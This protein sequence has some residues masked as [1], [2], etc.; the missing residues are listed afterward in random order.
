MPKIIFDTKDEIPES[1]RA[2]VVEVDGKFE[3]DAKGV[4]DKNKELL[5]DNSKLKTD[6]ANLETQ[7]TELKTKSPDVPRGH[8]IV[9]LDIAELG[10]AAKGAGLVKDELPTLKTTVSDLQ[11]KIAERDA[12]EINAKVAAV[13]KKDLAAWREHAKANGLRFEQRDEGGKAD[14]AVFKKGADGKEVETKLG[15]YVKTSASHVKDGDGKPRITP[16]PEKE[17]PV[18]GTVF[19]RIRDAEKKRGEENKTR[20]VE[21]AFGHGAAAKV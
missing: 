14:F 20:T 12:D 18:T 6:K 10:E 15:D 7:V 17:T 1:L 3:L 5:A 21:E 2:Q 11:S 9:A 16:F 8:R 4:L 19:D 13:A